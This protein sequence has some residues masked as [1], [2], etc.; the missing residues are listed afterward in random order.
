MTPTWVL[1]GGLSPGDIRRPGLI[2]KVLKLSQGSDFNGRPSTFHLSRAPEFSHHRF[3]S[4]NRLS[5]RNSEKC[6]FPTFHRTRLVSSTLGPIQTPACAWSHLCDK[7]REKSKTVDNGGLLRRPCT[8]LY[9]R[10]PIYFRLID[11]H[12]VLSFEMTPKI[13]CTSNDVVAG[14]A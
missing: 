1:C 12:T 8:L 7:Y 4:Q 5:S 11:H 13:I 2:I 6:V 14:L 3:P 9:T 10:P